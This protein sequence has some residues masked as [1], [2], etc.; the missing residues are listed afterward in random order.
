V[1]LASHSLIGHK[2]YRFIYPAIL[3]LV[4]SSGLGLA[5]LTAWAIE[6]LARQRP[7]ARLSGFVCSAVALGFPVLVSLGESTS[8]AYQELWTRGRAALR[9]AD[10][11]ARLPF[12]CGIGSFGLHWT[13]SAGYAHFH[14]RVPAYWPENDE[15]LFR[16]T[17]P[18]FN[19][20]LYSR[21]PAGGRNLSTLHASTAFASQFAAALASPCRRAGE[22]C[23]DP[24]SQGSRLDAI[25]SAAG[26][27][28]LAPD[29]EELRCPRFAQFVARHVA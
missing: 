19:V 1:I 10:F 29:A 5:Q 3:L 25:G 22:I 6:A 24:R 9:G 8:P 28:D 17:K 21:R 11:I 23:R 2:E 15:R 27:S 18:A 12:V 13:Q 20:L 16:K 26:G 4:L 14:H 7:G